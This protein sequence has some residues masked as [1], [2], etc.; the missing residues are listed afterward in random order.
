M[1]NGTKLGSARP[2]PSNLESRRLELEQE[3][4]RLVEQVNAA[5][6][7]VKSLRAER[8]AVERQR[9]AL[10]SARS[11]E[12]VQRE[13]AAVQQKLEQAMSGGIAGR[14]ASAVGRRIPDAGV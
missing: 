8:D 5:A 9:A 6:K 7:S 2:M 10:L 13:L 4:F 12:H 14:S 1:R 11:I 3:R